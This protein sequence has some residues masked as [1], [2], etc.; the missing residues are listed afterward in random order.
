MNF[1]NFLSPLLFV[2]LLA[3]HAWADSDNRGITASPKVVAK[4]QV[5][6]LQWYITGDKVVLSGGRFGK[7][8]VVT[9]KT[10]VL[11]RPL[12]T[13]LY[14]LDDY[15]HVTNPLGSGKP[16]IQRLHT[17]YSVLVQVFTMPPMAVYQAGQ[18]WSVGVI[19]GWHAYPV[20]TPD[21]VPHGL[22]FFQPH[23]D[24]VERMGVA[25]LPETQKTAETLMEDVEADIPEHYHN[26]KTLSRKNTTFGKDPAVQLVFSATD[27][28]GNHITSIVIAFV[29]NGIG[30]VVSGRT[31]NAMFAARR[32]ILERLLQSFTP[33]EVNTA[34]LHASAGG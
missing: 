23:E 1:R 19:K 21:G 31:S 10:Q 7:G 34:T 20:K 26:M 15:Y 28:A 17:R 9:G 11:D 13:T 12:K 32:P 30:F 16:A 27:P 22:V 29:H 14:T 18:D 8:V 5:V 24:S 33:R 25:M 3:S 4:G 2:G 6:K